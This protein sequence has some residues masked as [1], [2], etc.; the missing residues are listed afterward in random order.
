LAGKTR[1]QLRSVLAVPA[2]STP[3]PRSCERVPRV[4]MHRHMPVGG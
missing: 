1:S 2:R 3:V 4:W